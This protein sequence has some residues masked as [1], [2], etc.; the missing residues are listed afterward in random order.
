[1]C[2]TKWEVLSVRAGVGIP[3]F[4]TVIPSFVKG[5]LAWVSFELSPTSGGSQSKG[6]DTFHSAAGI[7]GRVLGGIPVAQNKGSKHACG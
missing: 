6:G 4:S 3:G 5:R 7:R 1:M 2:V